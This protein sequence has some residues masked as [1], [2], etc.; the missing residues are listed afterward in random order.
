[1]LGAKHKLQNSRYFL[2]LFLVLQ[3]GISFGL[4]SFNFNFVQVH[5]D[6]EELNQRAPDCGEKVFTLR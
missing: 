5:I 2:N 6:E 4:L 3:K 1:M